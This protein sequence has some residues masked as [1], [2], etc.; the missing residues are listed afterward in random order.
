MRERMMKSMT[1]WRSEDLKREAA[2]CSVDGVSKLS[3]S[4]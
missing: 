3:F 2:A 1:V 4:G